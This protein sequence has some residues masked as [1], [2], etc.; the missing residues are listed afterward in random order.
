MAKLLLAAKVSL[1]SLYGCVAQKKLNLIQ[2]P[3]D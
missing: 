1:C 3:S 2:F